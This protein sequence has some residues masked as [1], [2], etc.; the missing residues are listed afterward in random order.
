MRQS[1]IFLSIALLFMGCAKKSSFP[2]IENR[3]VELP[4]INNT[5]LKFQKLDIQAMGL[6]YGYCV[7]SLFLLKT[8]EYRNSFRVFNVKTEEDYGTLFTGGD[9]PLEYTNLATQGQYIAMP[10]SIMLWTR[11]NGKRKLRLANVT[12]S[13]EGKTTVI[14]KEYPLKVS[15]YNIYTINDTSFVGN[16]FDGLKWSF[17]RL[18]PVTEQI[19]PLFDFLEFRD[20][21]FSSCNSTL[22]KDISRIAYAPFFFN[23]IFIFSPDG[24]TRFSVSLGNPTSFEDIEKKTFNERPLYFSNIT[25]SEDQI[26]VLYEDFDP[27]I[28]ESADAN[29]KII[30]MDWDGN[31][32]YLFDTGKKL[33]TIFNSPDK[34]VMYAIDKD[35]NIYKMRIEP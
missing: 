35:E 23:Q 4:P 15:L 30:V 8:K 34:N 1:M 12:R 2:D 32:L 28:P 31:P 11:D 14:D 22:K 25:S 13:L 10:D 6:L 3:E 7:D 29:S 16:T 9:G 20:I 18:N 27:D 21:S 33:N 5:A 24:S 26:W 17:V 19:T